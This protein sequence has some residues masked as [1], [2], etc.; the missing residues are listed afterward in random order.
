M[1]R[2]ARLLNE[3]AANRLAALGFGRVRRE[4]HRTRQDRVD[5]HARIADT[6][7]NGERTCQRGYSALRGEIRRIVLIRPDDGP[8]A[9]R[10]DAPALRLPNHGQ[11]EEL[12]AE[13]C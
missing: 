10:E 7:L 4:Q 11:A 1:L 5:A 8:V 3:R 13:K 6:E 12:A 2:R 9:E